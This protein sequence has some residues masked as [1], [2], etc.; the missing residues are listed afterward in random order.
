MTIETQDDV[1]ALKSIGG[2][3]SRILQRM[4][5]AAKPGMTT[6]NLDLLGERLLREHRARS[7]PKMT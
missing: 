3:V 6:R 4:L 5:D 1:A 7:A 2:I